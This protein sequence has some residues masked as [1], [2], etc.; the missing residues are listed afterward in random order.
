MAT[1]L[2]WKYA[3]AHGT[4]YRVKLYYKIFINYVWN[5]QVFTHTQLRFLDSIIF[6]IRDKQSENWKV[7]K[8]VNAMRLWQ[9]D[10]NFVHDLE[11]QVESVRTG[12]L[13]PATAFGLTE[14][15]RPHNKRALLVS[16]TD[17]GRK[18]DNKNMEEKD[19][20]RKKNA[21]KGKIVVKSDE[22]ESSNRLK[23][24][25]KRRKRKKP[26]CNR[27]KLYVD[28]ALLGWSEW[29][30]APRGYNAYY[31]QGICKYPIPA[32]LKPTNHAIVQTT[33]HA[34]KRRVPPA[35]CVPD[36]LAGLSILFLDKG[37]SVVYKKYDKMIAESCGCK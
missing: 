7:F 18:R 28:F 31:C 3:Y 27:K 23:R 4:Q 14:K 32:H 34:N 12:Y 10:S 21:R 1:G 24:S 29:I 22:E 9:N 36:K 11:L 8:V 13:M 15:G 30:I 26:L 19:A 17:D 37:N 25:A 20:K 6:D 2:E 5:S 16:F 35:C 33:V